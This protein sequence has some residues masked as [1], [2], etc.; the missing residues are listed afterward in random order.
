[1]VGCT[2]CNPRE[3]TGDKNYDGTP[4]PPRFGL[5][6]IVAGKRDGNWQI[7]VAQNTIDTNGFLIRRSGVRVTPGACS[8]E[9]TAELPRRQLIAS[10]S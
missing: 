1:M 10:Q 7:E 3:M 2:D 9:K 8:P 4:R 5:M 6:T